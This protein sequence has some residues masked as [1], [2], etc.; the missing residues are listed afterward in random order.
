M[1]NSQSQPIATLS[2]PL[3]TPPLLKKGRESVAES[4]YTPILE[5]LGLNKNEAQIYELLIQTGPQGM[6]PILYHTK[7]KRGNAYYH[8]DNLAAKGLV[9]KQDLP[10]QTTKFV[11]KNP[12]QL[13]LLITKQKAAIFSAAEELTK[14]LPQLRSLYQ[15]AAIKPTVKYFEGLDGAKQVVEDSL[16]STTEIYSYIDSEELNKQ[17][18]DLNKNFTEARAKKGIKKKII[19]VDS[20]FVR[21]HAKTFNPDNTQ[22]RVIPAPANFSTIMYVYDN[23]VSYISMEKGQIVSMIIEHPAIYRMHKTLFQALWQTAKAA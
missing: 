16:T 17:F 21:Q 8:L 5:K 10:G 18:P 20:S 11:A 9:E 19:M 13:E 23:T 12:E 14:N 22:V 6:K 2:Q 15:L 7:L 4:P 3:P 1:D